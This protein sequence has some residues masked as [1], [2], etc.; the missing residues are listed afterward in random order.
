MCD[1]MKT[2]EISRLIRLARRI[3]IIEEL[4]LFAAKLVEQGV[5]LP[6]KITIDDG[7]VFLVV[8]ATQASPTS[9]PP[10]DACLVDIKV[11]S[12]RLVY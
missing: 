10:D 8:T 11:Q 3:D 6:C 4:Q 12:R 7:T 5:E 2:K 9:G 1:V